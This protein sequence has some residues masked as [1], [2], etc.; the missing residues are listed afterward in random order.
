M[1]PIRPYTG[2]PV[3]PC[4]SKVMVDCWVTHLT[5]PHITLF[6]CVLTYCV[7]S[8]LY[9]FIKKMFHLSCLQ[10]GLFQLLA[11]LPQ[12]M[13]G[14]AKITALVAVMPCWWVCQRMAVVCCYTWR[15]L[16]LVTLRLIF[17]L[18]MGA[19]SAGLLLLP[20]NMLLVHEVV[21]LMGCWC[22][23]SRLTPLVIPTGSAIRFITAEIF[24]D[25][26]N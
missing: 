13:G 9:F 7:H 1:R 24:H 21:F 19:M 10:N 17:F 23:W 16:C 14:H 26:E 2:L 12:T 22:R 18:K 4:S 3:I 20:E 6:F 11:W 15:K 25:A 5:S 8:A